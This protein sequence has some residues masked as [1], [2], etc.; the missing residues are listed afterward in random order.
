[1]FFI[2]T[3]APLSL[4]ADETQKYTLSTGDQV[5]IQV[6]GESDLSMTIRLDDDGI[7]SYPFLGNIKVKGLSL[8]EVENKI[9]MGLQP[10]YLK[11]PEVNVSIIQYRPFFVRGQVNRSG[12][13]PFQPG[14]TVQQAIS[15]AG[16]FTERAAQNKIYIIRKNS[17]KKQR[18]NK[19][20]YVQP[21]DTLIV[22]ESFF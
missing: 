3:I 14:L 19:N 2:F 11:K 17:R 20:T 15:I 18:V 21:D 13:Y 8:G 16:G 7:I 6:M 9:K 4:I 1:M 5:R 10:D 12:N 22:E